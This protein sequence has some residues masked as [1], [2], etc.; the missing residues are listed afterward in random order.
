M[1][2]RVKDGSDILLW[3]SF[4]EAVKDIADSLTATGI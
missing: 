2:A 4:S 1:D 3:P